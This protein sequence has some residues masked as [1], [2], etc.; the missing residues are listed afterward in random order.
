M[1]FSVAAIDPESGMAGCVIT[2]SSICVASRCAFARSGTGV[3]LTQNVTNPDLG[4]AALDA[5]AAGTAPQDILQ[6]FHE[7]DPGLQ[8]RQLGILN[9]QDE[10]AMFSGE[11]ALGIHAMASGKNCLAL[12][13]LLAND[14]V[15]QAMVD[16]FES[17]DEVFPLRLIKALQAGLAA[18]G[19]MGPVQSAG[20]LIYADP[21]WPVIDLRV[22]WHE[23]PLTELETLWNLYE[24]QM[25]P[26]I[27]RAK[28]PA[29][30]ESFGVPGDE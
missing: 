21:K 16:Y 12:G 4:P 17:S 23:E 14:G 19:E 9:M 2:S 6:S 15:P 20:V 7:L 30:S 29:E 5:L 3:A 13:N 27:V 10:K 18:G 8:W 28:N 25:S 26:Y 24:P 1:T 22:D 11:H